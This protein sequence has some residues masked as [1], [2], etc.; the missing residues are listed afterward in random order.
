MGLPLQHT[1]KYKSFNAFVLLR[2]FDI[3]FLRGMPEKQ[4]MGHDIYSVNGINFLPNKR[5]IIK[6]AVA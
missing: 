6:T 5:I 3:V 1:D 2:Y 4:M